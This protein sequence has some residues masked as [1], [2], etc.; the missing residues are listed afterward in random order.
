MKPVTKK[1]TKWKWL[2]GL[3]F[4]II[5]FVAVNALTGSGS[6]CIEGEGSW[7]GYTPPGTRNAVIGA[8]LNGKVISTSQSGLFYVTLDNR[9]DTVQLA[10]IYNQ[11][12]LPANWKETYPLPPFIQKGDSVFKA[13]GSKW[14]VVQRGSLRGVYAIL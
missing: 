10:F 13:K 7:P 9:G 12:K 3:L 11:C 1:K 4:V 5:F 8:A 14:F 2:G 6:G